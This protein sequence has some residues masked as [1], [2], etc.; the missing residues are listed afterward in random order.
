ME[1]LTGYSSID[2]YTFDYSFQLWQEEYQKQQ[3]FKTTKEPGEKS[4]LE[5]YLEKFQRKRVQ[6]KCIDPITLELNMKKA[7]E[8]FKS[9]KIDVKKFNDVICLK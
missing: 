4:D 9:G 8:Y 3:A 5:E 2:Y 1:E 7:S 6:I